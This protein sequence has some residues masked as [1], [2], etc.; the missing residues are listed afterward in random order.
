[1]DEATCENLFGEDS[2]RFKPGGKSRSLEQLSQES[3]SNQDVS[4]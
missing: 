2:L 3:S 1:M 4:T